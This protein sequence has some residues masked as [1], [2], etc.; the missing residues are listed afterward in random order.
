PAA[1]GGAA[2]LPAGGCPGPVVVDVGHVVRLVALDTQ[3][4]LQEGPKPAGRTSSC[5]TR[6]EGDVI[7]SVRAAVRTAGT[8]AV[9]VVGHHP[10]ASGGAH[11]GHFGGQG[12]GF[13]LR[14][15]TS[16]PGVPLPPSGAGG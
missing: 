1:G 11:G 7:D 5:P 14:R 4:W 12:H 2:L 8:R 10:P 16:G 6:S 13:P 15:P 9:V 3:W